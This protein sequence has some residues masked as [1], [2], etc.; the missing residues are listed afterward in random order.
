[1]NTLFTVFIL[2][3]TTV[4]RNMIKVQLNLSTMATVGTE[5]SGRCKEVAVLERF[6]TR[7]D[8]WI[9]VLW[10]ETK[11]LVVKRWP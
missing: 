8:V 1:M 9:F 4:T 2:F 10:D 5:E 3:T 7:V 6:Q 11:W